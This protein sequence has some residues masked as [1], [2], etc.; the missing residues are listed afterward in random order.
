MK[1]T[2]KIIVLNLLLLLT[3]CASTLQTVPM[4][5]RE[6]NDSTTE[7][8]T[9]DLGEPLIT[10][11]SEE[12]IKGIRLENSYDEVIKKQMNTVFDINIV[13]GDVLYFGGVD[14]Q[15]D[16]YFSQTLKRIG[17]YDYKQGIAINRNTKEEF[18]V[19]TVVY[20]QSNY[21]VEKTFDIEY[22][23][24]EFIGKK[25]STCFK[26]ELIYNGKQGNI[27]KVIYREYSN[28]MAR[29]AFTQNLDYDLGE[30]DIISFKGCKIKVIN[31]KNTGIQFKILSTFN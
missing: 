13:K 18:L 1:K 5:Y 22:T 30:G 27:I 7:V 4:K 24:T 19:L 10:K 8:I 6:Y 3:A 29:P 9:K 26:N 20:A 14:K 23:E 16:F 21:V 12:Y 2:K 15:R 11:G 25:C 31:A 28:D 17:E